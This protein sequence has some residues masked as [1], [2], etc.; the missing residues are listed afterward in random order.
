MNQRPIKFRHF[1]HSTGILTGGMDVMTFLLCSTG[2]EDF[3]KDAVWMQFT[4]LHDLNGV[5]IYEGDICLKHWDKSV[6]GDRE[7]VKGVIK[8]VSFGGR[9]T[10][11]SFGEHP[12]Y[13]ELYE[14]LTNPEYPRSL[15]E[16]IGNIYKS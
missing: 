7:P 5:E 8:W 14:N 4:G 9:Y 12:Y 3:W 13:C 10:H 2:K 16:V 1:F 11:E 6:Y 15:F